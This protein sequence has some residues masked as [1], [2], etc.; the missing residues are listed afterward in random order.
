MALTVDQL[1][2]KDL[3]AEI[4]AFVADVDTRSCNEFP[5][6]LLGLTAEGTFQM[7]VELGHRQGGGRRRSIRAVGNP[8][9][10]IASN[11]G[12]VSLP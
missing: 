1:L 6:L 5:H 3:V 7:G 4:D 11:L 12:F 8:G 2:I 9:S 10:R